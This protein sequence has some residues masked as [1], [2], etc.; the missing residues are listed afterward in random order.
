[1]VQMIFLVSIRWFSGSMLPTPWVIFRIWAVMEYELWGCPHKM[2]EPRTVPKQMPDLGSN[3]IHD[4]ICSASLTYMFLRKMIHVIDTPLKKTTLLHIC[5]LNYHDICSI[6][7]SRLYIDVVS[8]ELFH[9][10]PRIPFWF[11]TIHS[12]GRGIASE[13]LRVP[14]PFRKKPGLPHP[15]VTP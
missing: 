2:V 9:F 5:V 8:G 3:Q 11:V 6:Y 14:L 4:L 1:M 13:R 10:C 7:T 12:K 15:N